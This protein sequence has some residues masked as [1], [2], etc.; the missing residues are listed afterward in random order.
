[1]GTYERNLI[2]DLIWNSGTSFQYNIIKKYQNIQNQ[3][4]KLSAL[5]SN[6]YKVK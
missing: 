1:M 2:Q 3:A 4:L 6:A 5:K